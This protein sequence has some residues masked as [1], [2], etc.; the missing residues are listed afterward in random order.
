[1]TE[2]TTIPNIILPSL[3]SLALKCGVSPKLIFAEAGIDLESIQLRDLDLELHEVESVVLLLSKHIGE[4]SIGLLLGAHLQAEMLAMFGPLIASSPNP[5]VGIE[6]FSRFKQLLHPQFD[7][8]LRE[9][10]E[11]AALYYQ[12]ND[13]TPIGDLPFYAEALFSALV[14]LG[15]YFIGGQKKP[16]SVEFRHAKPANSSLHEQTFNCSLEFGCQT[17]K[18]VFERSVLDLP[19]LSHN[20]SLHQLFRQQAQEQLKQFS[21]PIASQVKRIIKGNLSDPALSA[22]TVAHQLSISRRTLYRQ[23]KA[24]NLCYSELRNQ[25]I[26]ET[27]K[28]MLTT[29]HY[30]TEVIAYELGYKDRSNF[31]HAFKRLTGHTPS[32][33]RLM[34]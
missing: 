4:P 3:S 19:H 26:I 15:N 9:D 25:V 30:S 8:K 34:K 28:T 1:M 11:Q 24:E 5:R 23:L 33:F 29:T 18:L 17:D 13:E 31:V 12:S 22:D 20:F 6:C 7:L 10:G 21:S 27:A 16:L 2:K 14:N 32:Q